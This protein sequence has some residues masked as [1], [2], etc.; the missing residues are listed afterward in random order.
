MG[1]PSDNP[2][3]RCPRHGTAQLPIFDAPDWAR[4]LAMQ[5]AAGRGTVLVV[6]GEPTQQRISEI[7]RTSGREVI[8][9]GTPDDAMQVLEHRG[10]QIGTAIIASEPGWGHRL[11]STLVAEYPEIRRITLVG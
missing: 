5:P 7:A 4:A 2:V 1:A 8:A 6:A 11:R 10:D 9:V 3:Q